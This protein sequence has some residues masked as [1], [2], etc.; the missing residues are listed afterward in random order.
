LNPSGNPVLGFGWMSV[1][2]RLVNLFTPPPKGRA[3][4]SGRWLRFLSGGFFSLVITSTAHTHPLQKEAA[5]SANI[6]HEP[7][8]SPAQE[9]WIQAHPV[10][11]VSGDPDWPPFS[12]RDREGRIKGLD[13][14]LVR[15]LAQSVGLQVEWVTAKNWSDCLELVREKKVDVLTGTARTE[16]RERLLAFTEPYL[17]IPMAIIVPIDA[18]FLTSL[19][20]LKNQRGALAKNYVSTEYLEHRFPGQ[21][22]IYTDNMEQALV[23]VSRGK[24]DFTVENMI[25]ANR[26]IR[27]KG[28]TNVKI[29]G[30]DEVNFDICY[31]VR[32]DLPEVL[33]ILDLA[34]STYPDIRKQELLARWIDVESR[35]LLGWR[36]YTGLILGCLAAAAFISLVF[37]LWNRMLARELSMRQRMEKKL[38]KAHDELAA[39]NGE[40]NKFIAMAAHDLK[41]PLTSLSL[42]LYNLRFLNE[43]ERDQEIQNANQIV[44]Y[45]AS[46]VRNLLDSHALEHHGH[47][48]HRRS[49]PLIPLLRQSVS[50]IESVAAAKKIRIESSF[51]YPNCTAEADFDAFGQVMDNL[52]S[53][54]V[55][56]S[57]FGSRVLLSCVQC[58]GGKIRVSVTDEGPGLTAEDQKQLFIRFTRLS[59]RP[60]GG[61][62]SY[63]LGLSIVKQLV[64]SMGGTTGCESTPGKGATFYVLLR[65]LPPEST[66]L[67]P[68]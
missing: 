34:L 39:S 60:T 30:V 50:R 32:R 33:A 18:P 1:Q 62:S 53:N 55:K 9:D 40:K 41:N 42:T 48:I 56:F 6:G 20:S 59:A 8:L 16:E 65:E 26:F 49:V 17:P 35:N 24:A 44:T 22:H 66:G 11:R 46:L 12:M 7:V 51:E 29:G 5:D 43:K 13:V 63:G 19:S 54:A 31:A 68:N 36:K 27:S 2:N 14:D 64:E 45:M 21:T 3:R 57:P 23:M 61:E 58:K 28:L 10:I 38:Q 4:Q 15:D 52:L 67:I 25:T 37:M 47:Q